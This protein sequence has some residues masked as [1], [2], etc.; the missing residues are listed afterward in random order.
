MRVN[1]SGELCRPSSISIHSDIVYVAEKFKSHVSAYTCEGRFLSSFGKP[2][3]GLGHLNSPQAIAV[4]KNGVVCVS[5][6]GNNRL[7]LF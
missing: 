3:I 5:D 1:G 2:R 6:T 7:Q 4:D